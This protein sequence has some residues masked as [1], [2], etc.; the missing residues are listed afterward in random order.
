MLEWSWHF[1]KRLYGIHILL[2]IRLFLHFYILLTCFDKADMWLIMCFSS[3][4]WM[5]VTMIH[6]T[7]VKSTMVLIM[8][9]IKI[10]QLLKISLFIMKSKTPIRML[11]SVIWR[12]DDVVMLHKTCYVI[13]LFVYFPEFCQ[14]FA[15]ISTQ[16]LRTRTIFYIQ[17]VL[18]FFRASQDGVS[19][20]S[21]WRH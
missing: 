6:V 13:F 1:L 5:D 4:Q 15:K 18:Q 12:H 11:T 21:L 8:P 7:W 16:D 9:G 14:I 2:K 20:T 17:Y 3:S 10:Q 19:M